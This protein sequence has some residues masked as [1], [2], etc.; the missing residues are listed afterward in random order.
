MFDSFQSYYTKQMF[1]CKQEI[2]CFYD[3]GP[4]FGTMLNNAEIY[5]IS[6]YYKMLIKYLI[7]IKRRYILLWKYCRKGDNDY[8]KTGS[9]VKGGCLA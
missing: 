3:T 5:I 1:A 9:C 2:L 8:E 7:F 6:I 4:F